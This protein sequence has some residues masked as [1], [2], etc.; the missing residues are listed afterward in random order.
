[1]RYLY[2]DSVP[3]PPQHDMVGALKTFVPNAAR[4]LL[5]DHEVRALQEAQAA[6]ERARSK[7]LDE[8]LAFHDAAK[9][10]LERSLPE[11]AASPTRDYARRLHDQASVFVEETLKSAA[12]A[13]EQERERLR[14]ETAAR[15]GQCREALAASLG[16]LR[17]PVQEGE[18]VMR[19]Q[20]GHHDLSATFTHPHAIVTAFTLTVSELPVWAHPRRV[21]EFAKGVDLPV[22]VKK[23]WFG[24]GASATLAHLDDYIV[25]GFELADDRAEISLRRKPAEKDVLTFSVRRENDVLIA[26]V[27]HPNEVDAQTLP[28]TLDT[29]GIAQVERLWQLLRA[30]VSDVLAHRERLIKIELDGEDVLAADR[31]APLVKAI[32]AL[33]APVV[34][35]V[36]KRSPN[37]QEL[38]LKAEN[39]DGRRE[40][41]YVKKADLLVGL[42]GLEAEERALFAPLGLE[43]ERKKSRE[44]ASEE[45]AWD[46]R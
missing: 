22:G 2:G 39:D 16:V 21:G 14:A 40:E 20:D 31:V 12:L 23:S 42:E 34:A 1:M 6:Q 19:L 46:V 28:T 4:A 18:V 27:H 35:E 15:R 29:A 3:F 7:T 25:G 36:A 32:V 5:L 43:P 37:A 9:Q 44:S 41:I 10:T 30:G 8:L 38:S 24:K 13:T 33:L 17:L 11:N 26:D 45:A